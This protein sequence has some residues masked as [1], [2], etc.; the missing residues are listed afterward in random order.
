MIKRALVPIDRSDAAEDILPVVAALATTGSTIRLIHVAPIPENVVT[1]EGRTIAYS[2]QEMARV[3][4]LWSDALRDTAARVHGAVDHVVR[5]GDPVSEILAEA[6][7]F[8]ADTIVVTTSTRS[9]VRRALLGSVAEA[10]LRQARVGV[11][12]YRPPRDA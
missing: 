4:A 3:Q 12:L 11:L 6:T 8:G 1:P 9:S 7:A 5:F 10:M 2:D